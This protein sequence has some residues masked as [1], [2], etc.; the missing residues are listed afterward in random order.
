MSVI[1]LLSVEE[2]R[3]NPPIP[4]GDYV[5]VLDDAITLHYNEMG[6]KN[7][8]P[9]L[10]FLP[11]SGPGASGYSNFKGN[12]PYFAERGYHT[13]ALDYIGY[14]LS[15]K[16][17][18]FVY[19]IEAQAQ[20]V[21][22][23]VTHLE[24]DKVVLIGNSL[25]G[26]IS[27]AYALAH[28]G[29]VAKLVLMASGGLEERTKWI[30]ESRGLAEMGKMVRARDFGR[31]PMRD[32]LK[33]IVRD[34]SRLTDD[35]LDERLAIAASQP[36]EVWTN[37]KHSNVHERLGEINVPVL[38]FWGSHDQFMP[39]RHALLILEKVADARSIV[40]NHAGH[41]FMIEE[42]ALFN[43]ATADFLAS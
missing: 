20:A 12:F 24:L 42:E 26:Y 25:G 16:P 39:V 2:L 22:D 4:V 28:P 13:I 40:S 10:I 8:R 35:V 32:I 9:T 27:L 41:W 34:P 18:D 15:D 33:L 19:D 23:V 21:H 3:R 7:D 36:S 14:G 6:T 11:G 37:Q 17:V 31:G 30:P 29:K 1:E 5:K 43:S 38:C